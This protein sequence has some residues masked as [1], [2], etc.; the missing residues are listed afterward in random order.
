M[1]QPL[2]P[3]DAALQ[4]LTPEEMGR[5]DR[6]TIAAGTPGSVLMERAGRALAER[7]RDRWDGGRIVVLAGPGN[8]GGDG[9]VAA[10][11]LAGWGFAVELALLG[12]RTALRGDAALAAAAWS[13]PVGSLT[14]PVLDGVGI[15]VD[16]LFGAGF[17]GA[18]TDDAAAWAMATA[19]AAVPVV[20]ADLPSGVDGATGTVSGAS[21]L[22]RESVTF[23]RAKPGHFLLPGAARAG[24]VSVVD[25]GLDPAAIAAAADAEP[26]PMW[27]NRPTSWR[28]RL[29]RRRA[30]AHKYAFG[31]VVVVAGDV[32]HGG[33]GRLAARSA[34][35]AG[36]GLVTLACPS[37]AVSV[38][39]A[40]LDAVMV[41]G[42]DD[43]DLE[44][45][46]ED[47]RRNVWVLGPGAGVGPR[48][49]EQ[50]ATVLGAGRTAVLDADALTSF[51][52]GLDELGHLIDA[53]CVLTPHA[54]EAAR[55]ATPTGDKVADARFLAARTGAVVV[56]K[57]FDS[58]I[59]APDGA[60][61]IADNGCAAL[62]TAGSGDVLAGLI[63]GLLAG[64]MAAFD[65]AA[66]AVWLHNAA[67]AAAQRALTADDLPGLV[68]FVL[69]IATERG[70]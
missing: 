8:N 44:P 42:V 45:L 50:V 53:A 54:G 21:F 34:L 62:A 31:H 19:D 36:A 61:R 38:N 10:R 22:A 9:F 24:A 32:S 6:A 17:R 63:A 3:A 11:W 67:G 57:G 20:A 59:A 27:R 26:G 35:A 7:V 56:L 15:V 12:E 16:A 13:G 66:A 49:R 41:R 64:G 23:G 69:P 39:A 48:L 5:V 40:R 47:R 30:D 18:L 65:A 70:P 25:I 43:G 37:P 58:V 46:L 2:I 29:P 1:P 68:R 28:D 51:A 60:V 14:R 52:D 55:L 33:A 4:L